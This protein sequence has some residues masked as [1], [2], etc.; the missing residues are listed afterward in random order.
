MPGRA[1][2]RRQILTDGSRT[3]QVFFSMLHAGK[4]PKWGDVISEQPLI[5]KISS[6]SLFVLGLISSLKD[7]QGPIHGSG[8]MCG[9]GYNSGSKKEFKGK[10]KIGFIIKISIQ[11]S[12]SVQMCVG[13][14]T[15]HQRA[16]PLRSRLQK[17]I[18]LTQPFRGFVCFGVQLC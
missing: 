18:F 4:G 2:L 7:N 13:L 6:V 9:L 11:Y 17:G 16:I 12:N 14:R 3:K 15:C 8:K 5:L 1:L 10:V